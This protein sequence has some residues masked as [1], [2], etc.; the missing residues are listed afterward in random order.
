M[1]DTLHFQALDNAEDA[2]SL[3]LVTFYLET[4]DAQLS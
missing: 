3:I 2:P 1:G 4:Y